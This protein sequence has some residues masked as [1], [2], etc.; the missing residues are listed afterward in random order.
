M[1]VLMIGKA[2]I[3]DG[4]EAQVYRCIKHVS[5]MGKACGHEGAQ[6]AQFS[7]HHNFTFLENVL[8]C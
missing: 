8:K 7:K 3:N 6:G 5:M 1:R 4:L 2:R